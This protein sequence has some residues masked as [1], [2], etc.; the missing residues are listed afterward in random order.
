MDLPTGSR[1]IPHD[2]SK[3]VAQSSGGGITVN[4]NI[5][6]NM[7]GNQEFLNQLVNAFAQR[8]QVAMAVR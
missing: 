5:A 8:L 4:V 2:I 3:Q 6:G 1:I 7:V